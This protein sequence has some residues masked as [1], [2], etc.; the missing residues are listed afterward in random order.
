MAGHIQPSAICYQLTFAHHRYALR[1]PSLRCFTVGYLPAYP[2]LLTA[3]YSFSLTVKQSCLPLSDFPCSTVG[4][5][6]RRLYPEDTV[7]LL[8]RGPFSLRPQSPSIVNP[9][10]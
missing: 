3:S 4:C 8:T 6:P 7:R 2:K 1:L 9:G 5:L 10:A